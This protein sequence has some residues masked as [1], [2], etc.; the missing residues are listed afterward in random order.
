M[1]RLSNSIETYVKEFFDDGQQ[2]N[3]KEVVER[4]YVLVVGERKMLGHEKEARG[5][6]GFLKR[7]LKEKAR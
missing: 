3:G 2:G 1:D 5:V 4:C 6:M 7:I